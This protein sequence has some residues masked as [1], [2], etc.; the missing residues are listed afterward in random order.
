M[1]KSVIQSN[2]YY[3]NNFDPKTNRYVDAYLKLNNAG[4]KQ[5]PTGGYF[6]GIVQKEKHFKDNM[7]ETVIFCE[8]NLN[9]DLLLGFMQTN[10]KPT[11]EEHRLDIITSISRTGDAKRKS[12]K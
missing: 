4:Y 9:K 3:G 11:L 10:W 7:V 12:R 1:P 8:E 6:S 5:V 2:W